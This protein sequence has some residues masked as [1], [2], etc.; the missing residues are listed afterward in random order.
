MLVSG[1]VDFPFQMADGF[2]F[3]GNFPGCTISRF[4]FQGVQLLCRSD[5]GSSSS[6][7][8]ELPPGCLFAYHFAIEHGHP[9]LICS[10]STIQLLLIYCLIPQLASISG[11]KFIGDVPIYIHRAFFETLAKNAQ[12]IKFNGKNYATDA[13]F[14]LST[15]NQ[16]PQN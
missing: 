3:H 8:C 6:G 15:S 12:G 11:W 4:C 14:Q 13:G 16:L 5:H 10:L 1:R 2:R 7:W 9:W